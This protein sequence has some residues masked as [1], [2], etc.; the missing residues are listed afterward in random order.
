MTTLL[1]SGARPYGSSKGIAVSVLLHGTIIAAAIYATAQVV[2]PPREKIEEHPILYVAPPPPKE[3]HVAPDPLPAVKSPPKAKSAPVVKRAEPPRPAQPRPAV[4][5]RVPATPALVAPSAVPIN[6]PAINLNA[7][8]TV[9]DIVAPPPPEPI[10]RPGNGGGERSGASADATGGRGGLGSGDAGKAYSENQVEKIVEVTRQ[11]SPR[12]PDALR[13]VGVEGVVQVTFVVGTNGRV[14]PGTI[15]V[16]STPHRLFSDAVRS[17][18]LD[19][20]F[21]PAEVGGR[22]VRQLVAQSF[23][24]KLEK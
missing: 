5:P 17:A 20:K 8:P 21:R 9:G 1:E 14:E 12:Y 16:T 22:P 23:Q 15:K 24:F 10:S 19:M 7:A 18:L 3:I 2:L 11:A 13:S 4:Q 6:V